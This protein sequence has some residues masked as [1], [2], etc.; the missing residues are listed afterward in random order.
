[1]LRIPTLIFTK[2]RSFL[3]VQATRLMAEKPK[4][5]TKLPDML[6]K[7]SKEKLYFIKDQKFPAANVIILR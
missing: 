4:F 6:E 7:N 3:I 5:P 1:M 2:N